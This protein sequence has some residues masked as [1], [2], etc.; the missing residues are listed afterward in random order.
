M[1]PRLRKTLLASAIASLLSSP[2]WAAGEAPDYPRE[3]MGPQ[4]EEQLESLRP[5]SVGPGEMAPIAAGYDNPLHERTPE[6]LDGLDILDAAGEKVGTIKGV[7]LDPRRQS[8][9]AVVSSG[10]I[11]GIGAKKFAVPLDEL[12]FVGDGL[13]V[14][15]PWEDVKARGEYEEDLYVELEEDRPISEAVELAPFEQTEPAARPEEAEPEPEPGETDPVSEPE[16]T[17]PAAE[18]EETDPE[19]EPEEAEPEPEPEET[20]PEGE[21]EETEPSPEPRTRQDY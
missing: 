14:T 4:S 5:T 6:E 21:P 8:V 10:G 18:P 11:L 17:D 3:R 15:T 16:G 2:V 20:D 1:N 19:G 9:H 13:Q 12:R 7:V